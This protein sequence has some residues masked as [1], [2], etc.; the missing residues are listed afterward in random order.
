MS[1]KYVAGFGKLFLS[2]MANAAR[3]PLNISYKLRDGLL[4]GITFIKQDVSV[5]M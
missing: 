1:H 4:S 3:H 5:L 2:M